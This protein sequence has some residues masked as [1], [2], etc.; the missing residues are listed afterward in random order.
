MKKYLLIFLFFFS[1]LYI[2]GNENIK[3]FSQLPNTYDIKLSPNGEMIGVLREIDGERMLSIINIDTK[4]L[5]FNHQYVKKGEIGGFE[6]L[7]DERLLMS[8]ITS[9][10]NNNSRFPTGELYAVNID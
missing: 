9:Y 2:Q 6:W 3:N 7:S 10:A 1:F 5:I 4:E 8:K